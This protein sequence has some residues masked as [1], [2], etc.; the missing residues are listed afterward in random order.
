MKRTSKFCAILFCAMLWLNPVGAQQLKNPVAE[1]NGTDVRLD[2]VLPVLHQRITVAN[3]LATLEVQKLQKD[4]PA[5]KAQKLPKKIQADFGNQVFTEEQKLE[6]VEDYMRQAFAAAPKEGMASGLTHVFV[7][8]SANNNDMVKATYVDGVRTGLATCGFPYT[9]SGTRLHPHWGTWNGSTYEG[10]WAAGNSLSG[11]FTYDPLTR[12]AKQLTSAYLSGDQGG[13]LSDACA[14]DYSSNKVYCL[15]NEYNSSYSAITGIKFYSA[16]KGTAVFEESFSI[17]ISTENIPVSMAIDKTGKFYIFCTD[18]KVYTVKKEGETYSLEEVGD[19]RQPTD[20]YAQSAAWDYR[21]DKVYW[22][23]IAANGAAAYMSVWDPSKKDTSVQLGSLIQLK[24]MA[25]VFYVDENPEAT[26][27]SLAYDGTDVIA[28]FTAPTLTINGD[29]VELG[30]AQIYKLDGETPVLTKTV[31]NIVPG[32][33][34]TETIP[35]TETEGTLTYLFRISNK[36]G[37]Y[38]AP[39]MADVRLLNIVL[40]Y[41]NGFEEDESGKME[42]ITLINGTDQTEG[43]GR[44][45]DDA[46]TGTYSYQLTGDYYGTQGQDPALN[47]EALAVRQ[48]AGYRVS[49]YYKTASVNCVDVYVDGQMIGYQDIQA[50]DGWLKFEALY[51]ADATGQMTVTIGSEDDENP[52][53]IDD[54][55]IREVISP[56][57]PG[58]AVFNNVTAATDGSLKA[59]VNMTLPTKTMGDETLS[60]I[61]SIEFYCGTVSGQ[62]VTFSLIPANVV[63]TGLTPGATLN[64]EAE[65]PQAG[66]YCFRA[67]LYNENGASVNYSRYEDADGYLLISPWIGPD[68]LT[69]VTITSDVK[70]DGSTVLSWAQ[71]V[72]SNGGYVGTVTYTIKEGETSL[73][74]GSETTCTLTG[75]TKGLHM[76]N[77]VMTNDKEKT[78]TQKAYTLSGMD[79]NA[80]YWN[81]APG[82]TTM[83]SNRAFY[84][85][86]T[87][88]N[89]GFSQAIYPASG[90]AMYI[91]TL[92]LFATAPT[93][94]EAKQYTKIYMGITKQD[95]F[96]GTSTYSGIEN[97]F[98]ERE[99]LTEVFADTLRFKAG[100]NT[101]KL[102]LKGFYYNG[103]DN[104]AITFVKPLQG[105]ATFAA[106]PYTG[107]TTENMSLKYLS[108]ARTNINMDTVNFNDYTGY[109]AN[110]PIPMVA[111][112]NSALKS[113]EITVKWQNPEDEDAPAVAVSGVG[114]RIYK[115][116][117]ADGGKNMD[118]TVL[119]DENGVAT[120][121]YMPDGE[122]LVVARKVG[123]IVSTPRTLDID[124][125]TASPIEI[126]ILIER[127]QPYKV[128]GKVIDKGGKPMA[129]VSVKADD[130]VFATETITQDNGTF[131]IAS[132][133]GSS[134][135]ELVFEKT[136]MR[137]YRMQLGLGEKDSTLADVTMDYVPVPVTSV[138]ANVNEDG[139][140]VVSWTKPAVSG[141]ISWTKGGMM[142]RRLT[143]NQSEAFKYAQRFLPA[144]LNAY[145]MEAPKALQIGFVPGSETADYSLVLAYDTT[146]EIFRKEIDK[147][148]LIEGEWYFTNVN[149]NEE[150]DFSRQLWLIVEVAESD[151]QGYAC[152]ATNTTAAAGKSNL[153]YL[154]GKWYMISEVF[155]SGAASV[156]VSLNAADANT[157]YDAANG[158]KVYRGQA[159]ADF[160]DFEL[161]TENPI[162]S[163]TYTDQDWAELEFGQYVYAV[164]TDWYE[165]NESKPVSTNILNKDM[166]WQ[167]K[168]V[169]T[170]DAGS[171]KGAE[172]AMLGK[173]RNNFLSAVAGE[174]GEVVF[175]LVWRDEYTYSVELPYHTGVLDKFD[176][177]DDIVI[178]IALQE[179]KVDPVIVSAEVEGLSVVMNWG[180]NLNNWEDDVESYTD[181]AIEN[182]GDYI[183]SEPV[184]KGGIESVTWTNSTAPQ[185]WIVFNPSKTQPAM[186]LPASSG[187]KMFA[188]FYAEEKN[189]DYLIRPV[190]KGGGEF[191]F[192]YKAYSA[193]YPE[194]FEVV[195]SSTTSDLSAFKSL[196]AYPSVTV[197]NW[198]AAVVEIPEDAKYVGIRCTSDDAFI[199]LVDDLAYYL[200]A[201]ANPTGYKLYLDGAMVKEAQVDELTYTFEGL[202][203][204][205]H[206][207]GVK[208]IYA[209]GESRLVE[210]T[211][212]IVAEA[213]PINLNATVEEN[214]A[215]L[216]WDMPEGFAP[217]AYKVYLGEELKAENLTEKTYTFTDLAAGNYTAAVVAVYETSESEKA[218]VNFTVQTVGVEE[219]SLMAQTRIYPNPNNGMFY[220]NTEVAGV[221][222]VYTLTGQRLQQTMIPGAGTYVF[223][224][225]RAR[226]M[227]MVKFVSGK[228]TRLFKVV[229]R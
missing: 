65:V 92:L 130:G 34:Y 166:K 23:N 154:Q 85:S 171:A 226:G 169:I 11:Y 31:E 108:S 167:V 208:A 30:T 32:Q 201:P 39:T 181:F 99:K 209:S 146:H 104:L 220:L 199:F 68:N 59:I 179:V 137:T 172:V 198:T 10:L 46:R 122:F 75:L 118:V 57:V 153:I 123:Y 222:E 36:A 40:P 109:V 159:E 221:A 115:N 204:G 148:E 207:V 1:S 175:D 165:D 173:E 127:A 176:L 80:T 140:M 211:V 112:A 25:S 3:D 43:C 102:P 177:T 141:E 193:N 157:L 160:E 24:G 48:G 100:E 35:V 101:L 120:F 113:V 125:E 217:K 111:V 87:A 51:A 22:A 116:P 163:L 213:K 76:L 89:S 4:V 212:T 20:T 135:Y 5:V 19:T 219:V 21:S 224:L 96:A 91:D 192:S 86:T 45:T 52:M 205:E 200:D 74:S 6:M 158:Y 55:E 114:V 98:I 15:L 44:T 78:L 161:L 138:A 88:T 133:Y 84:T 195:Y 189:N 26:N 185:S 9:N 197:T 216:T 8:G 187:S 215:V 203:M 164:T 126:E 119:T 142:A 49:F 42:N 129:G 128:E 149:I 72:G 178:D 50:G 79:E 186:N 214:M 14:Y 29:P 81:V 13:M 229:V 107:A 70:T 155:T 168:F 174:N 194:A 63:K 93:T 18:G 73:Y 210:E 47:I 162:A 66:K 218:T 225:N 95:G 183:L 227:Y 12:E 124:A 156:L 145:K 143:V 190:G 7:G 105:P 147:A 67:K 82:G 206:K 58:Y 16:D 37:K 64:L 136:G 103:E 134:E 202:S 54:I 182:I 33:K 131:E 170:S 110:T 69:S 184:R 150:L 152:A 41:T 60:G 83:V 94:G 191:H 28:R 27:L 106:V 180:L 151:N 56:D 77:L 2:K 38:S 71:T 196:K 53:Y 188:A 144:D 90:K 117:E 62:N 17:E 228:E 61:D 139:E 121:E 97:D 132:I 223:N